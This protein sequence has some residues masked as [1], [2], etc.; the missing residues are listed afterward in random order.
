MF[1]NNAN[2]YYNSFPCKL[3]LCSLVYCYKQN[4]AAVQKNGFNT[5]G[6]I[7]ADGTILVVTVSVAIQCTTVYVY[8]D[9]VICF[10]Y[11]CMST[12]VWVF[13]VM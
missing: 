11:T 1:L 7:S 12:C 2:P 8:M 5:G 6:L 13:C 3:Q 10:V 4:E 9:I